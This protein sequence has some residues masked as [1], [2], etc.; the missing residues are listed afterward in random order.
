MINPNFKEKRK[1][2][3]KVFSYFL[4]LMSIVQLHLNST[5]PLW[6]ISKTSN[7]VGVWISSRY[8]HMALININ[9]YSLCDKPNLK[10]TQKVGTFENSHSPCGTHFQIL[11]QGGVW[12]LT[13]VAHYECMINPNFYENEVLLPSKLEFC[14]FLT[15]K[16]CFSYFLS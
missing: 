9:I 7:A 11:P 12:N 2:K 5:H 4:L 16:H 8:F 1:R 3:K 15:F 13:G 10:I 6:K 14:I